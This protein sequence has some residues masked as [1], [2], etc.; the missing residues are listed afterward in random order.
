M[1][2][3]V[4][5]F[6]T[7]TAYLPPGAAGDSVALTVPAGA[8]VRDIARSLSIPDGFPRLTVVNGR[9]ASTDQALADGDIVTMFP[10]L[11]GG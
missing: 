4:R 2:I 5:L 6:S 7:L 3:E 8:T 11:V 10:P 1:R 9:D